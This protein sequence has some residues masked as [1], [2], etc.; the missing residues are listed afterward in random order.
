MMSRESRKRIR[1]LKR[2]ARTEGLTRGEGYELEM[3]YG[4]KR[5]IKGESSDAVLYIMLAILTVVGLF[6]AGCMHAFFEVI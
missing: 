1:E 4:F 2:K 5:S 3:L 6:L